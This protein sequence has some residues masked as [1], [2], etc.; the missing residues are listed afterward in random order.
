MLNYHD[1]INKDKEQIKPSFKNIKRQ[2]NNLEKFISNTMHKNSTQLFWSHKW[3][4][5]SMQQKARHS[6]LEKA[7]LGITTESQRLIYLI[8]VENIP[9]K[10]NH[11]E[12]SSM[13]QRSEQVELSTGERKETM[14]TKKGKI[15]YCWLTN[16]VWSL[17][18]IK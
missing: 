18:K 9:K 13:N 16:R 5:S 3:Y 1:Y 14:E 15:N 10:K 11:W 6:M 2:K 7:R 17:E 12:E 8:W 4:S